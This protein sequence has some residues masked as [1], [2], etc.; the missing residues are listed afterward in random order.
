MLIC[1]FIYA[2][3]KDADSLIRDM[4][5]ACDIDH[6]GK[7][8]YDE[9]VKFCTQAEK[10][11]WTLFQSIDRD[12]NGDLD[13][14]ELSQAF[15][16]AGVGVSNARLDRFFGYIDKNHDGRISFPEWR[17]TFLKSAPSLHA[18]VLSTLWLSGQTDVID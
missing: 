5:S 4:L 2:A 6:D 3:L 15:E 16:R 11:L 17:G 9:F 8:T 18:A 10:E 1:A 13:K 14:S 7:I 12:H